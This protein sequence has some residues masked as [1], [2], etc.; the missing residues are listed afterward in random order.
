MKIRS[1]GW[2]IYDIR[3]MY[4]YNQKYERVLILRLNVSLMTVR[5]EATKDD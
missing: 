1:V 3:N 4:N 5:V 2:I